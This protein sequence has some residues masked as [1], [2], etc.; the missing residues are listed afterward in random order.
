MERDEDPQCYIK[1][2]N[3]LLYRNPHWVGI[4]ICPIPWGPHSCHIKGAPLYM[5]VFVPP[6]CDFLFPVT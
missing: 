4:F 2:F 1:I 6:L 5:L 3:P